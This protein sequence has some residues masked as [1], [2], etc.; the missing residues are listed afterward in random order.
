MHRDL[1]VAVRRHRHVIGIGHLKDGVE[2]RDAA[3]AD[4]VRLEV[5]AET[6]GEQLAEILDL[7]QVL[8]GGDRNDAVGG[9]H[10]SPWREATVG[11]SI[12]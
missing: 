11:S 2:R 7:E 3:D 8:A 1:A 4:G 9:D 10:E 5:A 12:Q 6:G